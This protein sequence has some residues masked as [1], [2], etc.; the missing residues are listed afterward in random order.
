MAE[1]VV[2]DGAL[3]PPATETGGDRLGVEDASSLGAGHPGSGSP[4]ARST[5]GDDGVG[6]WLR[7]HLPIVALGSVVIGLTVV[8]I[9]AL[10]ALGNQHA[11]NGVRTSAL[12]A[13]RTDSVE[14]AS[15]DY[16]HLNR[17]FA[18]VLT[19]STPTY[20]RSYRQASDALKR[21]LTKYHATAVAKVVSAGIVSASSSRVVALVFLDQKVTNTAQ[22]SSTTDRSQVEITLVPSGGRWLIDQVV[23]L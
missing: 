12:A 17:D 19:H 5:A 23:L 1:E 11:L 3:P 9:L 16:R 14:L 21:T 6:S 8:V 2:D 20:R 15:Y 4:D 10:L 7:S 22:T 18:G 13:A